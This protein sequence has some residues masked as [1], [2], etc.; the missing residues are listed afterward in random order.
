MTLKA[1]VVV[2]SVSRVVD[3]G[4][5]VKIVDTKVFWARNEKFRNLLAP[6]LTALRRIESDTSNLAD[7][8]DR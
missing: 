4:W 5:K 1:A 7:F 8:V 3:R 2:D 6:V